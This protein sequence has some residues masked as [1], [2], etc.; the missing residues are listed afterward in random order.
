MIYKVISKL[1][2]NRLS[3]TLPDIVHENQGVFIKGR[4]ILENILICQDIVKLYNRAAV[5]PRCLFKIG[6]QKAYDTVEW[7]FVE[8][9]LLGL[10]FRT[11]FC[12]QVMACIK[13]TSFT[14]SLNGSNFGYFNGQRELKLFHLMFADDLLLFC[15]GNALSVMLLLRALSTFSKAS[16]LSMNCSKS[17]DTRLGEKKLSYAGRLTLINSVLNSLYSY[18]SNI[19]ILP[20]SIIRRIE[21]ICRNYLWDGSAEY[22][23]V[24][25]VGW[26]TITLPK[27]EGGLGIKK[28]EVWNVAIVAKLVD[29]IYSKAGSP[30]IDAAWT[31]KSICKVKELMK[32][33]YTDGKWQPNLKGYTVRSGYDWLRLH[34]NKPWWYNTVWNSWNVPKHAFITW[35]IMHIGMNTREK[36]Y[37]FGCCSTDACCICENATEI[38]PHL[39]FEYD[40]S[41][42]VVALIQ[43]WCGAFISMSGAM[44]G[45]Y[46]NVGGKLKQQVPAIIL[47]AC[48]YNICAQRNSP[49]INGILMVPSLVAQKIIEGV[50]QI[51]KFKCNAKM[52]RRDEVWLDK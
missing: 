18:W 10:K 44:A 48:I 24:P 41:K 27:I 36:L 15:N 43:Y 19:F 4:S 32:D 25:L 46:G 23:R 45:G 14:L 31:W 16:G 51:I 2:Y 28:A 9:L 26:D 22:H 33:A 49:R 13:T 12:Q 20:K 1:L 30:P 29:W 52:S 34:Q 6:L 21:A 5:S 37:R 7:D 8:N 38:Q 11:I 50:R 17:E 35:L 47:T 39:F 3:V 42:A 40:Y